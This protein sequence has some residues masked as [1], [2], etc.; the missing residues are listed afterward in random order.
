MVKDTESG[1][2]RESFLSVFLAALVLGGIGLGFALL[3]SGLAIPVLAVLGVPAAVA[4]L[5]LMNYLLWGQAMTRATAGERAEEEFGA[6][7]DDD[8]PYGD[9][10]ARPPLGT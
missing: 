5:C 8:W 7:V 4:A 10:S 2:S 6:L 9:P 3:C 1:S